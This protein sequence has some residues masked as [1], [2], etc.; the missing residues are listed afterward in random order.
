MEAN[1]AWTGTVYSID[2]ELEKDIESTSIF[3]T[4]NG[5]PSHAILEIQTPNSKTMKLMDRG[6]NLRWDVYGSG[7]IFQKN[8]KWQNMACL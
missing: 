3:A 1:N 4:L 7:N 5:S 2:V 8:L 6:Q